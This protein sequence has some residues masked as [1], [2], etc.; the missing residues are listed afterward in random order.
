MKPTLLAL[1]LAL[2]S[3]KANA[4]TKTATTK[5]VVAPPTSAH[6]VTLTCNLPVGGGTVTGYNFLRGTVTKGPYTQIGTAI[7]C[8]Y[9]DTLNL[10]EG[11][12][13]YYVVEATG[14]GGTSGNSNEA[15]GLIPF[16]PPGIPTGLSTVTQ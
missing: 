9:V 7:V 13:Y 11:T 8:I 3:A 1:L 12:T 2:L 14:P 6:S 10:V 4:Q 16:L 15:A 5:A